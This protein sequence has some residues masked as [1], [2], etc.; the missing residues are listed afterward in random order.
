MFALRIFSERVPLHKLLQTINSHKQ[1][2]DSHF[3]CPGQKMKR[4]KTKEM[5]RSMSAADD[6]IIQEANLLVQ[7]DQKR[8]LYDC[9][10]IVNWLLAPNW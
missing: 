3:L 4:S 8:C 2:S 6:G 1:E 10:F 5:C 9:R 7:T